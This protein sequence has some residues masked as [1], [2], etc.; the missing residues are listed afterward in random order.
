MTKNNQ[1]EY[2][3]GD[4]K[5]TNKTLEPFSDKICNFLDEFS[6]KLNSHPKSREFSDK[7]V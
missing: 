1:I 3:V 5:I 6:K 7:R 2:I 4:K